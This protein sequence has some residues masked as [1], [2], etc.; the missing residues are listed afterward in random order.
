MLKVDMIRL[1]LQGNLDQSQD[2]MPICEMI[3]QKL[4]RYLTCQKTHPSINT[5]KVLEI[6]Q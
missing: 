4:N 1:L 6:P 5:C 3:K 2:A